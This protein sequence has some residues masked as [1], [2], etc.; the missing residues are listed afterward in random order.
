MWVNVRILILIHNK[1]Q[2]DDSFSDV[3]ERETGGVDED[4]EGDHTFSDISDNMS[5]GEDDTNLYM[6]EELSIFWLKLL[7]KH[8]IF[9]DI[10]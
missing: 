6:L 7:V 4:M 3:P 1:A 5:Q 10:G 9:T 8:L 2:D